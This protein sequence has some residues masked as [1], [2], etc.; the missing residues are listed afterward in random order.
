MKRLAYF[1]P[2]VVVMALL[3]WRV[4]R[5]RPVIVA[6]AIVGPAI[7]AVYATGTVE[8]DPRVEV[9]AKVPG[10]IA[11]LLVKEGDR[12]R[13]GQLLAS[14]DNKS[15]RF[16]LARTRADLR[17]ATVRTSSGSPQLAALKAARESVAADLKLAEAE[18]QRAEGLVKK[19]AM[20]ADELDR[21]RERWNKL[22]AEWAAAD[23]RVRSTEIDL[24]AERERVGAL[25][26]S[27]AAQNA[28]AEIRAPLDGTVIKKRVEL[29]EAVVQ[30]QPLF[31]VGNTEHLLLE[32]KVDEA[33]V[34]RVRVGQTVLVDLFAFS[35]R[36]VEGRVAELYPDAD[37]ETKTFLAKVELAAP[38]EGLRSGMSAEVNIVT[39]RHEGATLVPAAAVAGGKLFVV[40]S[41]RARE[42]AVRTGLHDTRTVE[43]LE[44]VR[45][46]ERVVV[47]GGALSDGAHVAAVEGQAPEPAH[48]GSS[49]AVTLR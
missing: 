35:D 23:A 22:R 6:R 41:G 26:G 14:L 29:G 8:A 37:R 9:K 30:S 1:A 21:R 18:L 15:L 46:G 33:D 48:T 39:Q 4:A 31:T 27:V 17:A 3:G 28:D 47:L 36:V 42:R 45:P 38:P 2:L 10:T 19:G 49:S 20:A 16:D 44:G 12:V 13:A 11:Q 34:G 24:G 7:Q 25:E 32:V 40:E 5:P 43:V